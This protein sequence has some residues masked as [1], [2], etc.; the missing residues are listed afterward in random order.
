[1]SHLT[2]T[3][4]INAFSLLEKVELEA[5]QRIADLG[6]GALGHFVFPA[7]KLVGQR[8]VVFAV[9]IQR[10]VLEQVDRLA[11]QDQIFNIKPV[12]ADIEKFR[13]AAIQDGSLD[14]ALLINNLFLIKDLER[15]RK[16]MARL[17]KAGGRLIVVDWKT[18]DTPLGPPLNLRVS[19]EKAKK[20]FSGQL[21][22]FLQEFEP[23]QY[24]YGLIFERTPNPVT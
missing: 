14:M 3:E 21:F 9:D 19:R 8:G 11:K 5:G 15:A 17:T 12:W 20:I 16:E 24:H 7:A 6:C 18:S 4:L 22:K 23:G 1:M 10:Q 13:A 2:G